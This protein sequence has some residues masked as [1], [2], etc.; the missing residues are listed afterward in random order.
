MR[1]QIQSLVSLSGLRIWHCCELW[2]KLQM[3]LRT[4]AVAVLWVLSLGTSIC[5]RCNPKKT[6]QNKMIQN[7]KLGI[8]LNC[9]FLSQ[10]IEMVSSLWLSQTLMGKSKRWINSTTL[11]FMLNHNYK[12]RVFKKLNYKHLEM[13]EEPCVIGVLKWFLRGFWNT[14]IPILVTGI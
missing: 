14:Q 11:I 1:M 3:Q 9:Y 5:C 7:K 4:G 12:S 8:H 2:Y 6:K 10:W 13:N